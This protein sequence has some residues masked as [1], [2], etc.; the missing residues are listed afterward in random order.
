[1]RMKRKKGSIFLTAAIPFIFLV[2]MIIAFN[3]FNA[4]HKAISDNRKLG[5]LQFGL[6]SAMQNPENSLIY[7]DKSGEYATQKAAY[8]LARKGG[9]YESKCRE[10]EPGVYY[11]IEKGKDKNECFPEYEKSY[12]SHVKNYLKGYADIYNITL[13]KKEEKN[14]VTIPNNNY[15]LLTVQDEKKL[16]V[17]G[18]ADKN[19]NHEEMGYIYSIKPNFFVQV[20]YYLD[21]YNSLI[22][23]VKSVVN[24]CYTIDDEDELKVCVNEELDLNRINTLY[25]GNR[26]F[27]VEYDSEELLFEKDKI[28]IKFAF[29]IMS[30]DV[31]ILKKPFISP[32]GLQEV[33]DSIVEIS[34][35][36]KKI[37]PN[38]IKSVMDKESSR[39][40]NN[41]NSI[42]SK[43]T[44]WKSK[45]NSFD[46]IKYGCNNLID[47]NGY[48]NHKISCRY[49][50]MNL[51][52]DVALDKC[53]DF[54][55]DTD[56]IIEVDKNIECGARIIE[57]YLGECG[58]IEGAVYRYHYGND[59]C[60]TEDVKE[61]LFV[62]SVMEKC[63]ELGGCESEA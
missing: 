40:I 57:N 22:D 4:K 49:G 19:L 35:K 36:N 3:A 45:V 30:N 2:V 15:E 25:E 8:E 29:Y 55:T 37:N 16:N 59:I 24:K 7:I 11:W 17:Y 62:K 33:I 60:P 31:P 9:F 43:E 41:I 12:N 58:S 10:I 27:I 32:E 48:L 34:S 44:Q 56:S 18:F 21:E 61:D 20:D 26:T 54:I 14:L 23:T 39:N 1:M 5:E 53:E 13:E 47:V 6:L 38:L 50:L 28:K 46:C 42:V 52:Y 63:E 51:E